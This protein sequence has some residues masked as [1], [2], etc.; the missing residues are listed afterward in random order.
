MPALDVDQLIAALP[1]ERISLLVTVPAVYSLV[2]R[3]KDFAFQGGPLGGLPGRAD[4]Y[5]GWCGR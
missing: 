1:A 5:R 4:Q 2:L 3:H